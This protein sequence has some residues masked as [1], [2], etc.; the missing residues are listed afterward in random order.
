M[1]EKVRLTDVAVG[2][3]VLGLAALIE[4]KITGK[5]T[6]TEKNSQKYVPQARTYYKCSKCGRTEE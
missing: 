4:K 5:T 3:S 2:V 6:H 1:K